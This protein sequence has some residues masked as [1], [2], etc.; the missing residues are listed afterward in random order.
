MNL[1]HQFSEHRRIVTAADRKLPALLI[2]LTALIAPLT[3][4]SAFAQMIDLGT[5][6]GDTYSQATAVSHGQ[7]VGVSESDLTGGGEHAFIWTAA[8]GMVD[9]GTLGGSD[10][11]A[12]AVSNGQVVG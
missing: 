10:S 11:S 7:V 4:G 8:G 9:L 6:P 1:K 12:N 2:L 3:L 5:L